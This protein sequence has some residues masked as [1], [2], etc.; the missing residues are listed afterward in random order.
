MYDKLQGVPVGLQIRRL[1]AD[2]DLTL[3]QLAACS[4]TSAPTL[5]RYEGGWDRFEIRT[6]Q[7][8]AGALDAGL[9]VRFVPRASG[10][11]DRPTARELARLLA[12][13]FWDVDLTPQHLS[14]YPAWVL[15]RVLMYGTLAHVRPARRFFGDEAIQTAL[16]R[17]EVDER[18][19]NY[20]D[21]VLV[22]SCTQGS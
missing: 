2:R 4:G 8:I 22:N 6:L 21:V 5:H 17:R 18:T 9:E 14:R 7:R 16:K 12:A 19:R 13:L 20:W 15:S 3:E 1:R 10:D 11:I